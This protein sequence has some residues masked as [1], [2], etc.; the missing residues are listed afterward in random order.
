MYCLDIFYKK[1]RGP[2]GLQ[3]SDAKF[4]VVSGQA[5]VDFWRKMIDCVFGQGLNYWMLSY[6]LSDNVWVSGQG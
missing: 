3:V 1:F 2:I 6:V 5:L 4:R